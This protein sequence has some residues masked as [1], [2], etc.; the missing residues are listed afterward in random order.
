VCSSDLEGGTI[1]NTYDDLDYLTPA[2]ANLTT[3]EGPGSL[4]DFLGDRGSGSW[5]YIM[6]DNSPDYIGH[7]D[8]VVV[9]LYP[10]STNGVV[11][12]TSGKLFSG[13]VNP[14]QTRYGILSVPATAVSLTLKV[15][16]PNA[17]EGP[18]DLFVR[19]DDGSTPRLPSASNNDYSKLISFPGGSLTIGRGDIPPLIAGD[20]IIAIHCPLVGSPAT[21]FDVFFDMTLDL[22]ATAA[23]NNT[24][25]NLVVVADQLFTNSY[26]STINLGLRTNQIVSDVRVGV[27]LD[28]PRV[29][30]LTLRLM[31]PEGTSVLLSEN[32]GH[33]STNGFG[34]GNK[35][36]EFAYTSFAEDTNRASVPI[37]FATNA[38][39]LEFIPP[40]LVAT[41]FLE[42]TTNNPP[43]RRTA[44]N[45][46]EDRNFVITGTNVGSI[47][48]N[49]DFFTV[50]D[51]MRIYYDGAVIFDTGLVSGPGVNTI[52]YSGLS[53]FLEIVMNEG[54]S[55]NSTA[56]NYSYTLNPVPPPSTNKN[57]KATGVWVV[58][59]DLYVS[60]I[61]AA[62]ATNGILARFGLPMQDNAMPIWEVNWPDL[63]GATRLNGVA[64]MPGAIFVA[65]DSYTMTVDDK[66]DGF[67]QTKGITASFPATAPFVNTADVYGSLWHTQTPGFTNVNGFS[68]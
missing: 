34:L 13:R 46:H 64:A 9:T 29:S 17:G 40:L 68:S 10:Q 28:H 3:S 26:T 39:F 38:N 30:D 11:T 61:T 18:V 23:D 55:T 37:K 19:R 7:V 1:I 60:G 57:Q 16:L 5:Q 27:R 50:P 4:S 32:R 48:V 44:G 56:W 20:Y 14:G 24:S 8:G 62:S 65:G 36:G 47:T 35:L 52:F 67:K 63:K 25:T 58:N 66:A 21:S 33:L 51:E 42:D 49:Y 43:I 54:T 15:S 53:D 2:P 41:N 45:D 6:I 22:G 12:G 31:S 59:N